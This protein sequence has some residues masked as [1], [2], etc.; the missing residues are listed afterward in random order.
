[1]DDNLGEDKE[2]MHALDFSFAASAS[3]SRQN[4]N[5]LDPHESIMVNKDSHQFSRDSDHVIG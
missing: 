3:N 1:M 5:A 2:F 4:E